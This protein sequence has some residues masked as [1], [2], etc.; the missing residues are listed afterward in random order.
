MR[1]KMRSLSGCNGGWSDSETFAGVR[2][3]VGRVAQRLADPGEMV[4]DPTLPTA[5]EQAVEALLAVRHG[6]AVRTARVEQ[7]HHF[8]HVS[9]CTLE[10]NEGAMPAT[11]RQR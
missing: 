3:M 9:R 4:A 11:A 6:D 10:A 2:V 1:P 7:F 8:S 5:D